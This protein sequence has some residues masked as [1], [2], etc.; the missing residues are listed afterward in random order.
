MLEE[1]SGKSSMEFKIQRH[2]WR[3]DQATTAHREKYPG[4]GGVVD[5][6]VV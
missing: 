1:I 6:C 2:L 3:E 5:S 4:M